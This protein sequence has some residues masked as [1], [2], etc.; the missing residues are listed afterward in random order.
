LVG[1]PGN[2]GKRMKTSHGESG[3]CSTLQQPSPCKHDWKSSSLPVAFLGS[4]KMPIRYEFFRQFS[5]PTE[6]IITAQTTL[7]MRRDNNPY[8]GLIAKRSTFIAVV[9]SD[10][11]NFFSYEPGPRK[12]GSRIQGTCLV[13]HAGEYYVSLIVTE[14]LETHYMK[15]TGLGFVEATENEIHEFMPFIVEGGT[16]AEEGD[17][18]TYKLRNIREVVFQGKKTEFENLL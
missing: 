9:G 5:D 8:Y 14:V 6:V 10:Y 17:Y 13:E 12:W 18:R 1:Q 7:Q 11:S 3:C 16:G 2:N 4:G 15:Y